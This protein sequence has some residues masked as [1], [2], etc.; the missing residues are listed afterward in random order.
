ME[1]QSAALPLLALA[2]ERQYEIADSF[3]AEAP[4]AAAAA[5]QASQQQEAEPPQAAR[6]QEQEGGAG[7]APD[8]LAG[9]ASGSLGSEGTADGL[10]AMPEPIGLALLHPGAAACRLPAA[11]FSPSSAAHSG[12]QSVW[13]Y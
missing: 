5:E 4:A 12:L 11:R 9:Q 8:E 1:Q 10:W 2:K 6:R 13:W 3:D 7:G